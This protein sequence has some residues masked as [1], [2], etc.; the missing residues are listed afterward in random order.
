MQT[1]CL[2]EPTAQI[3]MKIDPYYQRKKSTTL[4]SEN[5]R[6]CMRILAG[7]PLGGG[8]KWEWGCRQRQFVPISV[9]TSSETSEIRPAILLC[10]ICYPLLACNWLQNEWPRMTLSGYFTPNSVFVP[11][12]LDKVIQFI[13]C[14]DVWY[15]Y[16]YQFIMHN[17]YTC[18]KQHNTH[19]HRI[20]A[21]S[22]AKQY[23]IVTTY[24]CR[25]N[26]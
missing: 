11:E 14:F 21:E 26:T 25:W 12:V 19:K 5:I 13:S 2:L 4:V 1:R 6:K 3:W 24:K 22:E 15:L 8:L 9:A 16:H 7:V 23:E 18:I 10:G 20:N 17:M